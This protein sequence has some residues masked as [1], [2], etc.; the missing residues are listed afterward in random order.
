MKEK[1]TNNP[2]NDYIPSTKLVK[3]MPPGFRSERAIGIL[4]KTGALP[5]IKLGQTKLVHKKDFE[6]LLTQ[7][8]EKYG[9]NN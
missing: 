8:K 5:Y 2:F 9:E 6:K 4:M 3:M 1:T 7:L